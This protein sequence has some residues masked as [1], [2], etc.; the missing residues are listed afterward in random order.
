MPSFQKIWGLHQKLIAALFLAGLLPLSMALVTSYLSQRAA[1]TQT[2]GTAYQRLARE[3]S[4]KLDLLIQEM[5]TGVQ[6]LAGE[7]SLQKALEKANASYP[8]GSS[9]DLR[10]RNTNAGSPDGCRRKT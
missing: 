9:P 7:T 6:F 10:L 5:V 1:I 2:M 4:I 8:L 3:T